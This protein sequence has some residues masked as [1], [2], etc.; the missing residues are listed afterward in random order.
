MFVLGI[1]GG[2]SK[3]AAAIIDDEGNVLGRG[4]G[5]GTN[6]NFTSRPDAVQAFKD[7][8]GHALDEAGL[9]AS[10]ITCAGSTFSMAAE[11]AFGEL[12]LEMQPIRIGEPEV[13]FER[14]GLHELMGVALVA[15]TGSSCFASDGHGR[16]AHGGGWG[17]LLG[18]E[19]SAF[20]IGL[21]GI[22]RGLGA[23]CGRQPETMLADAVESYFGAGQIWRVIV[24][25]GTR[26][27]Q[28]RVA[29]FAVKVSEAAQAGDAAAVEI[30]DHAGRELADLAA[31]VARQ[32]F[33]ESD[34]FP[35]V[36]GGGVFKAGEMVIAPIRAVFASH[37]PRATLVVADGDP[38]EAVARI[39]MRTY[40]RRS[41]CC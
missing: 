16:T 8:I 15:G 41:G 31:F 39:T 24:E 2:G 21:R 11:E 6:T 4:L 9:K 19:G 13:V 34:E 29:G 36:L 10:Q 25:N 27:N 20:D 26:I 14:A 22:K 18:D 37:F 28:S 32:V 40:I 38:G 12:G 30:L 3:T 5:G 35:V 23:R 7:A 1:D 33:R 17:A